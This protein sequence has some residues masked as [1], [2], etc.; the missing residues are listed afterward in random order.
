MSSDKLASEATKGRVFPVPMW[1]LAVLLLL[2]EFALYAVW[3][4]SAFVR[5]G[6]YVSAAAIF[7]ALPLFARLL[8]AFASYVLSRWK[9][10]ALQRAQ[11]MGL[12]EVGARVW[13]RRGPQLFA[14]RLPDT[15]VAR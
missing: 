11:R 5:R 6:D 7:V 4:M 10:V 13:P 3:V 12:V 1:L 15:A 8:V 14:H 2:G 9:G